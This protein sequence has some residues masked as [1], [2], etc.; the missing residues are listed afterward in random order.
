MNERVTCVRKSCYNIMYNSFFLYRYTVC[1]TTAN[2]QLLETLNAEW[3]TT[4][5][6]YS[7]LFIY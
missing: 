3:G 2:N 4:N 7:L 5:D 1:A 6:V